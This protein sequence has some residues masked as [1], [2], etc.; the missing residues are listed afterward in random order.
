VG[1]V[2]LVDCVAPTLPPGAPIE[3]PDIRRSHYGLVF[4]QPR[5]LA[6]VPFK[7]RLQLFDIPD[8]LF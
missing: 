7:G 8:H 5:P 6:H 1:I 4:A 3:H 2:E